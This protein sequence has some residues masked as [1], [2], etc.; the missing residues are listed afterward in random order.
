MSLSNFAL[1]IAGRGYRI[2][3]L[4][5]KGKIP[6]TNHGYKDASFDPEVINSWWV[7]RPEANIG[8]VVGELS[9]IC[10]LDVDPRNGGV[11]SLEKLQER[12][13][14]LPKTV[15]VNTGGGGQHYYYKYDKRFYVPREYSKGL[16]IK[17]SGYVVAPPSIHPSGKTYEWASGLAL[18]EV[19]IAPVPQWLL[20]EG[21]DG[22][23]EARSDL[24]ELLEGVPQGKRNDA[25]ASLAGHLF[26][27]GMQLAEVHQFAHLVNE[28]NNPPLHAQE[29]F[30]VVES[31]HSKH[32]A[33][34]FADGSEMTLADPEDLHDFLARDIPPVEFFVPGII[35]KKGRTMISAPTNVGK[36][37]LVQNLVLSLGLGRDFLH[38]SGVQKARTLLLDFEMGES[39]VRDRFQ[40]MLL[41]ETVEKGCIHFKTMLGYNLLEDAEQV[42]LKGWIEKFGIEVLVLDPIGSAWVGDENAKQEVAKL[43]SFLDSLIKEYGISIVIV[44]HWRKATGEHSSGGEM[45]AGS[46]KWAA[47]V[48]VHVTLKGDT[49]NLVFECHKSRACRKLEPFRISLNEQ[50]LIF[51][52]SGDFSKIFNDDTLMQVYE[53]CGKER[54][55]VPEIIKK[56]KELHLGSKGTIWKLI[57]AS[58]SF[59]RDKT[60]NTHYLTRKESEENRTN[61][62]LDM[63]S[64][65]KEAQSQSSQ[66]ATL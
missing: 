13:G 24:L 31:I 14:A 44:H 20:R 54:V 66:T 59:D 50:T 64:K 38:I 2:L 36:S 56:A 8:L 23:G 10:V 34:K 43:T 7:Q 60:G 25:M 26:A 42:R 39:M 18:G 55:A 4:A 29:V 65:V 41:L 17:K 45:A 33:S 62:G 30:N 48:D 58:Q 28:K 53:A 52:F 9:G 19:E 16:D 37:I 40:K 22:N 35:Q 63:I 27:R 15:T 46:Y 1:D 11:N 47:W 49:D 6:C 21:P 12:F 3:P 57:K 61:V 32:I 5:A 51:A